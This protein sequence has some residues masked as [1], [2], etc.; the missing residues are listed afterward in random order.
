MRYIR[1]GTSMFPD[2]RIESIDF[3]A[4]IGGETGVSVA[5]YGVEGTFTFTGDLARQAVAELGPD[6]DF[7]QTKT[8]PITASAV[9][10]VTLNGVPISVS[11]VVT[12]DGQVIPGVVIVNGQAINIADIE[13]VDFAAPLTPVVGIEMRV[14]TD[15]P[16][17]TRKYMDTPTVKSATTAYPSLAALSGEEI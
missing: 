16:G 2:N 4:N 13:W 9:L 17:V 1:I 11:E 7:V 5:L 6:S 15:A 3:N 10:S 14:S 12:T 8:P